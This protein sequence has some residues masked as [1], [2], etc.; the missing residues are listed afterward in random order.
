MFSKSKY[1]PNDVVLAI[2]ECEVKLGVILSVNYRVTDP[3]QEEGNVCYEIQFGQGY[4]A[5][6]LKECYISNESVNIP[7]SIKNLTRAYLIEY[8][9]EEA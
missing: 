7:E 6:E 8:P 5:R 1:N 3:T 9:A 4:A 2:D